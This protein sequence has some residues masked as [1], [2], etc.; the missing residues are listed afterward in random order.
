MIGRR[1]L[2]R[3]VALAWLLARNPAF[4]QRANGLPRVARISPTEKLAEMEGPDPLDR[5]ARAFVHG[6]RDL[7]WI[8]GR[9]LVI[10]HRSAEGRLERLP[11]LLREVVDL[12]VDVIVTA[13]ANM[14]RAARQA[15]DTIPIVAVGPNPVTLGLAGSLARPGGN[16][17]GL[18]FDAGP[19]LP[20]KRLELLKRA[21]PAA[22]RIAYIRGRPL[23]GQAL[24][25]PETA[26]A[27]RALGVV[28]SV[29]AVD[30]PED[31]DAA[32]LNMTRNRPDAICCAETPANV[33][34]RGPIVAFAARERLPAIYGLPF[35]FAAAGGLMSYGVSLA[36][37]NR[38]SASYVDKILKG[39]K[40]GDLA[41]EQPTR[42]ELVINLKTA[43]ALGITI[44]NTLL[45]VADEVIR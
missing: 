40:P 38:R 37:V 19:G 33:A 14:A 26:A 41:V 30:G 7:G 18:T 12:R 45:L 3:D 27:A 35:F 15:T 34:L 43:T 25:G 24:W 42:F 31:L 5:V 2:A 39:A 36:E 10:E 20:V 23:P 4:A 21:V 1:S 6:L 29:V 11:A 9:D 28:L 22:K 8:D 17:T 13:G 16:V 32:F 44:P